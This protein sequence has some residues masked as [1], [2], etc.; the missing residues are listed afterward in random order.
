MAFKDLKT[1]KEEYVQS[2]DKSKLRNKDTY[3]L[4][5]ME[6]NELLEFIRLQENVLT[7]ADILL[8]QSDNIRKHWVS[9]NEYL[10]ANEEFR[11][12][13]DAFCMALKLKEW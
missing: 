4:I 2:R 3:L 11:E 6:K 5:K 8:E 10:D 9:F 13:W 1:I 7:Q 12:E